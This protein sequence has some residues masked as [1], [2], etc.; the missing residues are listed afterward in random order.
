MK[1]RVGDEGPEEIAVEAARELGKLSVIDPDRG[2]TDAFLEDDSEEGRVGARGGGSCRIRLR[3]E[4]PSPCSCSVMTGDLIEEF[5]SAPV[6]VRLTR[7]QRQ[8]SLV[9][10]IE[11]SLPLAV[12]DSQQLTSTLYHIPPLP[13][14]H[15]RKIVF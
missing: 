4:A 7:L 1:L 9:I 11:P 2:P 3:P 15:Q 14:P 10:V 5:E 6:T 13:G 12:G 8:R